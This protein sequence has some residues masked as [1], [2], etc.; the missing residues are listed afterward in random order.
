MAIGWLETGSS[1]SLLGYFKL[2]EGPNTEMTKPCR[3]ILSI[4]KIFNVIT[5]HRD[6]ATSRCRFTVKGDNN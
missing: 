4:A 1:Y 6:F 2:F 3:K 5:F